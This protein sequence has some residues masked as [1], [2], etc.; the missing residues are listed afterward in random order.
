MKEEGLAEAVGLAMGKIDVMMPLLR[1][2]PFDVLISHNRYTLLNRSA[3]EMFDTAFD[4]GITI[5]MGQCHVRRWT[6]ELLS[7]ALEDGDV[8]GLESF[9]TH[10]LPLTEAP[11]GYEVFRA[12]RDG[13]L[14]VVLKP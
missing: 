8:L 4:K 3:D 5:R 7:I 6:D 12:K 2:W 1:D 13:C 9:A 11:F 10:H 14:K